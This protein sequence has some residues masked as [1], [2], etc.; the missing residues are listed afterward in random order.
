MYENRNIKNRF[1]KDLV[2]G[3]SAIRPDDESPRNAF[4]N[5]FFRVGITTRMV[6]EDGIKKTVFHE[7]R[8][9][10]YKMG[11]GT[12]PFGVSEEKQV[13]KDTEDAFK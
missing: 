13:Q 2:V 5:K 10:H 9:V 6:T 1:K 7:F 3:V 8:H 11:L 12:I 4:G